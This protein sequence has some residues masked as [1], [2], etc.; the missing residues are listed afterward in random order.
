MTNKSINLLKNLEGADNNEIENALKEVVKIEFNKI[1]AQA[2]VFEKD[3][4]TKVEMV[5]KIL[6]AKDSKELFEYFS[7]LTIYEIAL[8]SSYGIEIDF[9]YLLKVSEE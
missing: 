7:D 2:R 4:D 8:I 9:M 1:K 5:T 3:S 6:N